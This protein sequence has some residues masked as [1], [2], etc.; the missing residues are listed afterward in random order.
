MKKKNKYTIKSFTNEVNNLSLH[1]TAVDDEE[2][3]NFLKVMLKT[4]SLLTNKNLC[5]KKSSITSKVSVYTMYIDTDK[6][7]IIYTIEEED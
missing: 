6:M 7:Y 2:L 4:A 5:W 3:E 1:D